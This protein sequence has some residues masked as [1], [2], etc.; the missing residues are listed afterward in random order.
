MSMRRIFKPPTARA[1]AR[2]MAVVVLPTPPFWLAM[3][4]MRGRLVWSGMTDLAHFQDAAFAPFGGGNT[5]DIHVPEGGGERQFFVR[6]S[7]FGEEANAAGLEMRRGKAEQFIERGQGSCG[8][9]RG[10]GDGGGLDAGIVNFCRCRRLT[11]RFHEG[12]GPA[13]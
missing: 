11:G 1:A 12:G 10:G 6:R 13:V 3:A 5:L 8:D 2:L 7:S 9:D 4:M